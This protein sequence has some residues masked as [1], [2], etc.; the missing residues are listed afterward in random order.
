M[1]EARRSGDAAGRVRGSTDVGW[2]IVSTGVT[3]S[4]AAMVTFLAMAAE[5][6]SSRLYEPKPEQGTQSFE[7]LS[8]LLGGPAG[9][10][11]Y[12]QA[13]LV[14]APNASGPVDRLVG[15][16]QDAKSNTE[17][18]TLKVGNGDTIIAVLQGA[19][20]SAEDAAAVVDAMKPLYSP[21]SIR[22]GQIFEATFG[23][24][25]NA[26]ATPADTGKGQF[27]TRLPLAA[28]PLQQFRSHFQVS[29]NLPD[30][31]SAINLSHRRD[32]QISAVH[33]PGQIHTPLHSM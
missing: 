22:S 3:A 2:A 16:G 26:Q 23:P 32:L 5:P 9:Q 13:G 15:A 12:R 21:R 20:V 18:K 17:T 29:G 10:A 19:G 1:T 4:V 7:L 30:A 25:T 33:S 14:A 27:P 8:R 6:S 28:R 11:F 31:S 24:A